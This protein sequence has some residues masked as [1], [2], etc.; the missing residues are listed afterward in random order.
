M[1]DAK[2]AGINADAAET[3]DDIIMHRNKVS[4]PVLVMVI[5]PREGKYLGIFAEKYSIIELP[6]K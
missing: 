3:A 2:R 4:V 1:F 5:S 6:A